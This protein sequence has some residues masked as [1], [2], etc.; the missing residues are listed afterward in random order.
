MTS[1]NVQ[2]RRSEGPNA[3]RRG[4][5]L[6]ALADLAGRWRLERLITHSDGRADRF[7]GEAVFGWS[8]PRLIEDQSGAL[9]TAEG[10]KVTA[11]RRYVWTAEPGRIEVL[12]G[13]MRPFHTIPLR[14]ARPETTH[15]CPPDRYAVTYDFT[16]FPDWTATWKVEGP[17]KEY[18]MTCHYS[19]A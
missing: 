3:G 4:G 6:T 13:D 9:E 11:T 17:R 15:L 18:R 1:D 19:P 8:G 14:V 16:Q 5:G 2:D 7:S 10:A 12:F